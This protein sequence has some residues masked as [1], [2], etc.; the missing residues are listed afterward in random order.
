MYSLKRIIPSLLLLLLVYTVN[1]SDCSDGRGWDRW[2]MRS[3]IDLV[4]S[5]RDTNNLSTSKVNEGRDDDRQGS[6]SDGS[7]Q[8][9]RDDNSSTSC[10]DGIVHRCSC[11]L[12]DHLY[13][14]C[15]LRYL[16]RQLL[17]IW[18]I[19]QD[20][21]YNQ[22]VVVSYPTKFDFMM[23]GVQND[24]ANIIVMRFDNST[25]RSHFLCYQSG[26][27]RSPKFRFEVTD[28]P[29]VVGRDEHGAPVVINSTL[30][31]KGRIDRK[32]LESSMSMRGKVYLLHGSNL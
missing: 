24:E 21:Y 13:H 20:I 16:F 7:L 30:L 28:F 10:E 1:G 22:A 3:D 2:W 26:W 5:S 14:R 25:Y 17:G 31:Y 8:L 6:G 9:C 23:R 11:Q 27:L 29:Y 19:Y 32:V 18:R 4:H 12:H 15:N